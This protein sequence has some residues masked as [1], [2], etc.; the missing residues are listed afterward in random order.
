LTN[1]MPRELGSIECPV[2]I[3]WG[4]RDTLLLPRQ[5]E[6]F[7]REIPNAELVRLPGLGHAPMS[8]DP[9]TVA[10]SILEFTARHTR[11]KSLA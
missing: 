4:T 2:R 1:D 11:D 7:V 10:D 5:A 6:R 9:R 3:V 8:D